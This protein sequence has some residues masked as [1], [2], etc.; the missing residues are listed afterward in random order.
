MVSVPALSRITA[1]LTRWSW[2]NW[3][4]P[5]SARMSSE[6]RSS[7]NDRRRAAI[8][9]F[10]VASLDGAEHQRLRRLVAKAFTPPAA[11]R[12]RSVCVDVISE[13][14]DGCAPAGHCDFVADIAKSYPVQ[15]ICA[16][17]GAPREDWHLFSDWAADAGKAFGV[18]VVEHE[19]VILRAWTELDGL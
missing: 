1:R 6:I 16:L 12:M 14:V 3:S 11:E 9:L 17:L 4:P 7:L 19:P 15:I 18:N 10:D 2:L 13:L 5:S 8:E